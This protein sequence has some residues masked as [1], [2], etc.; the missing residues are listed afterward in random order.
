T[1]EQQ[2]HAL[3]ILQ[4]KLDVL[5]TMLDAMQLAYTYNE[6]PFHSCR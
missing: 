1:R 6:P 2:E 5:W 4:F 3:D